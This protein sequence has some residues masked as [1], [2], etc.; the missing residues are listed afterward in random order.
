METP[1]WTYPSELVDALAQ[2]G[3]APTASTSPVLVRDA[4]SDLYRFE[5]RRAR[6]RLRAGEYEKSAYL[7]IVIALRKKYWVL[8]LQPA[9]WERICAQPAEP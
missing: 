8:T 2:L 6:D 3:L 7:D 4:V 5:L 9:A 1:V